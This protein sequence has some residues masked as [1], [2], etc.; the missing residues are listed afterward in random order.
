MIARTVDLERARAAAE[1]ELAGVERLR[2]VAGV[3]QVPDNAGALPGREQLTI[4]AKLVLCKGAGFAAQRWGEHWNIDE[5]EA[6][7]IAVPL[8]DVIE[9]ETG[10]LATDPWSR[11]W[12]ALGMYAA[13]RLLMGLFA[14]PAL[15][16]V[17]ETLDVEHLE[18]PSPPPAQAS[19]A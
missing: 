16:Q 4:F 6:D 5:P 9:L 19:A 12:L 13:P 10:T 18:Q 1:R 11:L 15:A 7:A 3:G 8:L 14:A 2:D 17:K